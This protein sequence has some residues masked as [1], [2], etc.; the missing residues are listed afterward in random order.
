MLL[1]LRDR[2]TDVPDARHP[3]VIDATHQ[4]LKVAKAARQNGDMRLLEAPGSRRG[5]VTISIRPPC[6][7]FAQKAKQQ[8]ARPSR[9]RPET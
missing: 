2:I 3:L 5:F 8:L 6:G 1:R 9:P 4:L 7:R